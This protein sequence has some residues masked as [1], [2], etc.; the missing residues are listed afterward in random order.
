MARTPMR[1]APSTARASPP[2][3]PSVRPLSEPRRS[4]PTA[5]DRPKNLFAALRAGFPADLNAT[6]IES[7]APD[8]STRHYRWADLDQASARIANLLAAHGLEPGARVAVQV[9]KS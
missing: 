8:G 4:P 3:W 6:A 2:S 1:A 9:E 7:V 5:M